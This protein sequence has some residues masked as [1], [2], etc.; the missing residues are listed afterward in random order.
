MLTRDT[1]E[2]SQPQPASP[3]IGRP[4]RI[5]TTPASPSSSPAH[6]KRRDAFAEPAVRQGRGQ[7]RLQARNQRR[8]PG[9]DRMRDRDRGSAEVKS[10]HQNSRDNA[11]GDARPIRPWRPRDRNDDCHQHN[12]H[13][14]ADGEIGQRLGVAQHVFGGD[15]A[16]AP[17]HDKNRRRRARG[18][19]FK[20]FAHLRLCLPEHMLSRNRKSGGTARRKTQSEDF[21]RSKIL[22]D[23]TTGAESIRGVVM[24]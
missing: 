14:H 9:G 4:C 5:S 2:A 20:V 19:F 12:H 18:Q 13:G 3:L 8:E 11:V 17:E 21:R 23:R 7:D 24:F 15:K 22:A 16:G 6:C 1:P 10:V